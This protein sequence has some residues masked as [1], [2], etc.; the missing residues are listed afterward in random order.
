MLSVSKTKPLIHFLI[1]SFAALCVLAILILS[2]LYARLAYGPFE[3][4]CAQRVVEIMLPHFSKQNDFKVGLTRLVWQGWGHPIEVSAYNISMEQ[5]N[6]HHIAVAIP[7]LNATFRLRSLLSGQFNPT[8]LTLLRPSIHIVTKNIIDKT[9]PEN[10]DE[11]KI[12]A[13]QNQLLNLISPVNHSKFFKGIYLQQA[14]IDLTDAQRWG[15]WHLTNI[16]GNL[17]RR[18]NSINV[19]LSI[20]LKENQA[21]AIKADFMAQQQQWEMELHLK[22][23]N[24]C[25]FLTQIPHLQTLISQNVIHKIQAFDMPITGIG[26]II[27]S[28]HEKIAAATLDI[29]TACGSLNLYPWFERPLLIQ[30]AYLKANYKDHKL[31]ISPSSLQLTD[32]VLELQTQGQWH[33][34]QLLLS[35]NSKIAV[36][37]LNVQKLDVYWPKID[38]VD[39]ARTWVTTHITDGVIPSATLYL[40]SH[41]NFQSNDFKITRLDGGITLKNATLSHLDTMPK[42]FQLDADIVYDCTQ[43]EIKI[44]EGMTLND[45]KMTQGLVKI[46]GLDTHKKYLDINVHVNGPV[47]TALQL[48]DHPP[49]QYLK[50]L[51]TPL[52][53]ISGH[54]QT[55]LR[56]GFPLSSN[57][58]SQNMNVWVMSH[59]KDLGVTCYIKDHHIKVS[60][61]Q[62]TLTVEPQKLTIKG[63]ARVHDSPIEFTWKNA[64]GGQTTKPQSLVAHGHLTP[65]SLQTLYPKQQ[66]FKEGILAFDLNYFEDKTNKMRFDVTSDLTKAHLVMGS[67]DKPRNKRATLKSQIDMSPQ[68]LIHINNFEVSSDADLQIKANGLF[69][70]RKNHLQNLSVDHL[71]LGQTQL[72]GSMNSPTPEQYLVSVRGD[73]LDLSPYLDHFSK[74]DTSDTALPFTVELK[75]DIK[76]IILDIGKVLYGNAGHIFYNKDQI[77]FLSYCA[78]TQQNS[79]SK[80]Y[81]NLKPDATRRKLTARCKNIGELLKSLGIFENFQEGYLKL[82]AVNPHFGP[83]HKYWTGKL[84]IQ[85]FKLLQVP[86]LGRLLSMAFPSGLSD[87]ASKDQALSFSNYKTS[88]KADSKRLTITNGYAYGPSLGF[89]INGSVYNHLKTLNIYG[90]IMPAYFLNTLIAKVPLI[91]RL[92]TG[93][94]NE[95]IFGVA[96]KITGPR[97]QPHISINPVS[98]LTPGLLRKI[99]APSEESQDALEIDEE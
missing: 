55:H 14:Q 62:M 40:D 71:K 49:L 47:H 89:S 91:G 44:H 81:I 85:N 79:L 82:A 5:Q 27:F 63:N 67:I 96:Y 1:K 26:H 76:K 92:I 80:I 73:T 68:Q 88:F 65:M 53:D 38:V 21:F 75:L 33:P 9:S 29:Q 43:F 51:K 10:Q 8:R 24:P 99:F 83:E 25:Q 98:A 74:N 28:Q 72:T 56:L 17:A 34:D 12:Q 77:S 58:A 15:N 50:K 95:G 61:G 52:K 42:I 16:D 90:S 6:P 46:S 31:E 48:I 94:K 54:T 3:T 69:D 78:Q 86:F 35:L 18:K 13:L 66:F 19:C 7:E 36:K 20:M 37:K 39:A 4:V 41:F 93:G 32:G 87:F 60:Q 30:Q 23:I 97:A 11:A 2:G 22:N 70:L 84:V 64:L 45:L 59:I 57:Q